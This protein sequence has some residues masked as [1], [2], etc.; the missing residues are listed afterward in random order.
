MTIVAIIR[1]NE[2]IVPRDGTDMMQPEDRVYFVCDAEHTDR[3][4]ASFGHTEKE[5]HSVVIAGGGNIG[6]LLAQD[7]E[8]KSQNT[9]SR[10]SKRTRL[11]PI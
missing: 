7:I 9:I 4:M 6:S 8:A 11:R 5:A 3:A 2:V 1:G 10:L